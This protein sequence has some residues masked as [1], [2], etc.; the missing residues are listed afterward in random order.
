MMKFKNQAKRLIAKVGT[1]GVSRRALAGY[2]NGLATVFMIHRASGIHEGIRGHDPQNL[3]EVLIKLKRTAF[4]LVSLEDV[5][6]AAQGHGDLPGQS[7][8]FTMDDGYH[9][10]I[11]V[12]APIFAKHEVPLTIFLTTGFLN[13]ELWTWDAKIHWLL[14]QNK[15]KYITL[16]V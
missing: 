6:K 14:Q 16:K 2:S 10:Q 8:A 7:I 12:L 3:E 9:D 15:K 11:E 5:V 4:N 1:T 13:R